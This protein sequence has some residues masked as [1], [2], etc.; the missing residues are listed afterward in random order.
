[1]YRNPEAIFS[2]DLPVIQMSHSDFSVLDIDYEDEVAQGKHEKSYDFIYYMTNTEGEVQSDCTGWGSFAKNWPLAKQAM[3]IMCSEMGYTGIVMGIVDSHGNSCDLPPSC[4][5]NVLKVQYTNYFESLDYMRQS[6][7][8]LLP[9]VYDASPRVA[10][11][12]MS[13]NLP[14]LMNSEIVGGWK[15]INKHTGEFFRDDMS[16]FRSSLAKL[17]SNL[18]TYS[19]RSYVDA[20]YGSMKAGAKLRSFVEEHFAARVT[21]PKRS[22]MLIPSEPANTSEDSTE[23]ISIKSFVIGFHESGFN[24]FVQANHGSAGDFNWVRAENGWDQRVADEWVGLAGGPTLDVSTYKPFEK[25]QF[26]PHAAGETRQTQTRI[27]LLLLTLA[28]SLMNYLSFQAATTCL[29]T[30]SS[31]IWM[32]LE[33]TPIRLVHP[34]HILSLKTTHAASVTG[35]MKCSRR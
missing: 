13:L 30:N 4:S 28:R 24:D 10:V 14:L 15:Y 5:D 23:N 8:L 16:D 35:K 31:N 12:A 29:T 9:Q 25:D 32:E 22:K 6:K 20:N 34:V 19:P 3:D 7:F 11:E 21:L 17:M 26:G 18:D 27:F 33:S 2:P 1:M